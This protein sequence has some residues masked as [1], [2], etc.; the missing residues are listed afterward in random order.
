MR[1][2]AAKEG[3]AGLSTFWVEEPQEQSSE[4]HVAAGVAEQSLL[5]RRKAR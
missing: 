4:V 2:E 1:E 3:G 5:L